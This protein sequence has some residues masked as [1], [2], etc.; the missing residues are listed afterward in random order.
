VKELRL[1]FYPFDAIQTR[2]RYDAFLV[3]WPFMMLMFGAAG[4]VLIVGTLSGGLLS[5]IRAVWWNGTEGRITRSAMPAEEKH[6]DNGTTLVQ[7][8]L[9]FQYEY[10]LDRRKYE[11][12]QVDFSARSVDN[13]LLDRAGAERV[14]GRYPAGERVAVYFDPTEPASAVLDRRG[15]LIAGFFIGIGMTAIATLVLVSYWRRRRAIV[16]IRD[17]M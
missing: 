17:V 2:W 4:I 11:S 6:F 5:A 12:S 8:R 9:D 15:D 16:E 13:E 14:V 1:Q 7:Y 3:I 10:R